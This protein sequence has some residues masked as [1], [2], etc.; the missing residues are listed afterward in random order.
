MKCS[1]P[2]RGG[3]GRFR[4]GATLVE[5]MVF[6]MIAVIL[7]AAAF[8]FGIFCAKSYAAMLN[9]SELDRNSRTCL[10]RLTRDLRQGRFVSKLADDEI[11]IM[12]QDDISIQY[13]F[14]ALLKTLTRIR[15]GTGE[16]LLTE[17]SSLKFTGYQRNPIAGT[18]DQYPLSTNNFSTT[19]KLVQ[20]NWKC[21]RSIIGIALNTESVQTAKIVLRQQ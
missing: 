3:N 8:S 7:I 18:Y 5:T 2:Y 21:S 12:G 15:S 20:V 13:K 6:S 14:D 17:C 16:R 10:D 19:C 9:Y 1:G 4:A 11:V